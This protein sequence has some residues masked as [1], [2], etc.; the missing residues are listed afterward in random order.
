[1]DEFGSKPWPSA[2]L[3]AEEVAKRLAPGG[4][5]P[6]SGAKST[7]AGD[8]KWTPIGDASPAAIAAA[9]ERHNTRAKPDLVAKRQREGK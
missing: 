9:Q 3:S 1:M 5:L 2:P 4:R 8:A 6:I 7:V